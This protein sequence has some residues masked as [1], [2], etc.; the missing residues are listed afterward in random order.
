[1]PLRLPLLLLPQ[2]YE[3]FFADF[4]PLNLGKTYRFCARTNQLL[5]VGCWTA[6]SC[7]AS[8]H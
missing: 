6:Q 7:M 3:P 4:G 2:L 5:Q 1:V 8:L